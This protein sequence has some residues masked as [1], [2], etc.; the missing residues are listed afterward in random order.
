ML[1]LRNTEVPTVCK[2][3]NCKYTEKIQNTWSWCP[4]WWQLPCMYLLF[5]LDDFNMKTYG[6]YSTLLWCFGEVLL[7]E[8]KTWIPSNTT[9]WNAIP[10]RLESIL[11]DILF[12]KLRHC[13]EIGVGFPLLGIQPNYFKVVW[14]KSV[15]WMADVTRR[16][17]LFCPQ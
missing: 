17:L 4:Q 15:H 8:A 16:N 5:K 7:F 2:R 10:P 3:S 9:V 11:Q 1:S 12:S 14:M 6:L 13:S